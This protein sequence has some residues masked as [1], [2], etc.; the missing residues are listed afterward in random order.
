[1]SLNAEIITPPTTAFAADGS[2]DR[3]ATRELLA[4]VE[5]HVDGT[6]A[7]GTTGEFPALTA[8]ERKDLVADAVEVFGPERTIAHVGG[9]SIRQALQHLRDAE[10]VG[11]RRHAAIT[12]YYL[13]ASDEGVF[14]YYS[15]LREAT[16][17]ELY[18]YIFPDVAC[19]DVSPELLARLAA[20]G[21]DGVKTSGAASTRVDAYRE[22]APAISLWSGNDADLPHVVAAGGRGTVSGV[23]GVAPTAFAEL[24]AALASGDQADIDARQ[25]VVRQLVAALGPSIA[26]LKRGLDLLGLPGGA[27]RMSIDPTTPDVDDQIRAALAAAGLTTVS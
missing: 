17:G 7:V 20:A 14:R 25:A 2:V 10:E 26:R 8:A 22:A 9:P 11:A 1:M 13:T 24:R 5:P 4:H 6:F 12:P 16:E 18:V 19:S 3:A 15:A 21:L 27:T 23:S